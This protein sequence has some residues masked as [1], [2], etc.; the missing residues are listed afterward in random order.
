[1]K[2]N[3]AEHV[4]SQG[5]RV[6]RHR[7]VGFRQPH[8]F[9]R[10]VLAF[11]RYF[12]AVHMCGGR[13]EFGGFGARLYPPTSILRLEVV[14][15][16]GTS[17]IYARLAAGRVEKPARGRDARA[18]FIELLIFESSE[19]RANV[20]KENASV[21]E[22]TANRKEEKMQNKENGDAKGENHQHRRMRNR[23]TSR[24]TRLDSS[25]P[26]P[27]APPIARPV[28]LTPPS[29]FPPFDESPPQTKGRPP[30]RSNGG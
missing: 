7:D 4:R 8:P 14:E 13:S 21:R 23:R 6:S 2:P 30:Q 27:I 5:R 9:R 10:W 11:P 1:M 20:A 29:C 16:P 22:S 15:N 24:G 19:L 17:L 26:A 12:L 3:D 25:R 18:C 28:S